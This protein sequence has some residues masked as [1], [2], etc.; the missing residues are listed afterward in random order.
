MHGL[1][2]SS[3]VPPALK[4]AALL[5]SETT[6]LTEHQ[7]FCFQPPRT[8]CL[9]FQ[10]LPQFFHIVVSRKPALDKASGLHWN[11]QLFSAAL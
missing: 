10:S 5:I 4:P 7:L 8:H 6:A 2:I 11:C 1:G 3:D 9:F